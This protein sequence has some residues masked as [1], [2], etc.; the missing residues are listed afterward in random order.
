MDHWCYPTF[1]PTGNWRPPPGLTNQSAENKSHLHF[2]K[3]LISYSNNIII[4]REKLFLVGSLLQYHCST[5]YCVVVLTSSISP[6]GNVRHHLI[7]KCDDMIGCPCLGPPLGIGWSTK[8]SSKKFFVR[9]I[10]RRVHTHCCERIN[11]SIF[12]ITL[13]CLSTYPNQG[14]NRKA[15]SRG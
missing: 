13:S 9:A 15:I 7:Q 11:T 10:P 4:Y 12:F 5:F 8:N 6:F 1:L 14:T 3:A 2:R